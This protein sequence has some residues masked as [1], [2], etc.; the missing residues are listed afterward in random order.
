MGA[1]SFSSWLFTAMLTNDNRANNGPTFNACLNPS[2]FFF[3]F[4]I[5]QCVLA[6]ITYV[7]GD[8]KSDPFPNLAFL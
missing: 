5:W 6:F 8:W 1:Q 7:K 2:M 3:L 4:W